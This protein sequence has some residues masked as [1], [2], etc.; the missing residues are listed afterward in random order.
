MCG[1]PGRIA[2]TDK[3][4]KKEKREKANHHP[5]NHAFRCMGSD[6]LTTASPHA[7]G[8]TEIQNRP[9]KHFSAFPGDGVVILFFLCFFFVSFCQ[10]LSK[11]GDIEDWLLFVVIFPLFISPPVPRAY[12]LLFLVNVPF[13]CCPL[14]L[15]L[16]C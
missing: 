10:R 1:T 13:E 7:T 12:W 6:V 11:G 2:A 5:H 16:V 14:F 8:G 4:E 15:L 3:G 9:E